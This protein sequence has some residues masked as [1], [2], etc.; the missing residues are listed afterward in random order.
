MVDELHIKVRIASPRDEA[1]WEQLRIAIAALIAG[2][3]EYRR[4]VTAED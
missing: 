3:P 1:A 4:I 2:R